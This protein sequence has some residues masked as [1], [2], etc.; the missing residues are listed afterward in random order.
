[1]A[2]AVLRLL[3]NGAGFQR[4]NDRCDLLGLMTDDDHPTLC[5]QWSAGSQHLLDQWTAT[6][7]VQDLRKAGFQT[8]AFSGR[9]DNYGEIV[10]CHGFPIHSAGGFQISPSGDFSCGSKGLIGGRCDR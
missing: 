1:M 3:N 2:S 8:R 10:S 5:P 9:E 6:R 4:L 7:S